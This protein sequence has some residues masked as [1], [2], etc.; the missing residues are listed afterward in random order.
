MIVTCEGCQTRFHLAEAQVPPQGARVRCSK[1]HHRF[2]VKPPEAEPEASPPPEPAAQTSPIPTPP[3]NGPASDEPDLD[4]PEFLFDGNVSAQ[5]AVFGGQ[6]MPLGEETRQVDG[7]E[8]EHPDALFDPADSAL[9]PDSRPSSPEEAAVATEEPAPA[10]EVAAGEGG[11]E[12]PDDFLGSDSDAEP[13]DVP[14]GDAE[15]PT[16][17]NLGEVQEYAQAD[18][19]GAPEVEEF[20]IESNAAADLSADEPA[21]QNPLAAEAFQEMDEFDQPFTELGEPDGASQPAESPEVPESPGPELGG[22]D[23]EPLDPMDLLGG[24]EPEPLSADDP[25]EDESDPLAGPD[26]DAGDLLS[27]VLDEEEDG[28]P[29]GS[30]DPLAGAD[31]PASSAPISMRPPLPAPS[32]ASIESEGPAAPRLEVP[33]PPTETEADLAGGRMTDRLLRMAAVAVGLLLAVAG[34]SAVATHGLGH[35]PGP[36]S[37][38]GAGWVATDIEALQLRDASERRVLVLRGLLLPQSGGPPPTITA[39]LL[40]DQGAAIG[41][42]HTGA[43]IRLDNPQLSPPALSAALARGTAWAGPGTNGTNG[44]TVLI[45]E[46]APEARRFEIALGR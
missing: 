33:S 18:P 14:F 36:E 35:E 15:V 12:L 16:G 29:M 39:R 37:L 25:L 7:G 31:T 38:Q 1:C 20:E 9:D 6:T 22:S 43:P 26:L 23:P 3:Q 4:N 8:I 2:L 41:P 21:E 32:T 30:W 10:R 27:G 46:P 34:V 13:E 11:V 28:D 17:K 5:S 40:D 44:F 42:P 45:P 19:P 24:E